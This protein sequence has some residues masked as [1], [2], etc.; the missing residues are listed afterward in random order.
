MR[1]LGLIAACVMLCGVSAQAAEISGEYIEARSCDVF[2]GPC[3]ANGDVG[4]TGKEAMMAWMVDDGKWAGQDVSG[5]GVALILKASDTLTIGGKYTTSNPYP[6]ETVILVDKRATPSQHDSLV[7]FV[8]SS[9]PVLSKNVNRIE[10]VALSLKTDHLAGK[11]VFKAGNFASIETRRMQKGDC[12]CTNETVFYPPLCKVDNA[13]PA[14]TLTMAFNG[15]GL[16]SNWTT[17]NKRSAFLAT[18]SK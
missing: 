14:Y 18:F 12:V 7:D 11:G 4:L 9:A 17:V 8:K 10:S 2:T 6:I 5:L 3:F 16:N 15:K 13:H 1:G